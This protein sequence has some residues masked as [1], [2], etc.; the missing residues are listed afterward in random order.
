[1]RAGVRFQIC[2]VAER[3]AESDCVLASVTGGVVFSIF[4]GVFEVE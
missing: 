3:A 1:M 4:G 2:V